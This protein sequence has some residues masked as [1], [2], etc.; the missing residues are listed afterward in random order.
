MEKKLLPSFDTEVLQKHLEKC[1]PKALQI[2]LEDNSE[3]H[4]GH[5]A[6][7]LKHLRV[8]LIDSTF[9]N[10]PLLHRHRLVYDALR[11]WI[12][13]PIHSLR[14]S[15]YPPHSAFSITDTLD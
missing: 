15:A 13:S 12:P 14:I 8:T 5:T 4:K 1:F 11:E 10:L 9:E 2:S 3:A 7:D 6:S